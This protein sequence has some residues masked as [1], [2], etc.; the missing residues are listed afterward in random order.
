MGF[1]CFYQPNAVVLSEIKAVLKRKSW[2]PLCS[3]DSIACFTSLNR[4]LFSFLIAAGVFLLV[5]PAVG[6]LCKTSARP[7][8]FACFAGGIWRSG[9]AVIVMS[10]AFL[11]LS[12]LFLP[13]YARVSAGKS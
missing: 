10:T 9:L 5:T 3:S 1:K 8:F 13:G 6:L 2:S 11:S 4:S 7:T 12:A